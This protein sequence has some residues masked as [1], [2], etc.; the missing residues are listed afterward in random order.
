MLP[1]RAQRR[2]S[3]TL[4][5]LED[6]SL[7]ATLLF[8]IQP[9]TTASGTLL[10]AIEVT[11]P[12]GGTAPITVTLSNNPGAGQLGGTV[13]K[14]AVNGKA[15][16]ND[17]V[18]FGGTPAKGYTL[19]AYSAGDDPAFSQAFD[20]K[21]GAASLY[22]ATTIAP[23]PAGQ[24]LG[25]ITVQ[26][27]D[28]NGTLTRDD[29]TTQVRLVLDK[30]PGGARFVDASGNP[31]TTNPTAQ[32]SMGVATFPDVRLD[33]AGIGYTLKAITGANEL[34]KSG[35]S[36]RFQI[37]AGQATQL[38]FSNQPT[39][40]L[41]NQPINGGGRIA[42]FAAAG[43]TVQLL[44]RFNNPLTTGTPPI[45]VARKDG[46]TLGGLLTV[47]AVAG[48]A[49]FNSLTVP[50]AGTYTLTATA[51]GLPSADSTPFTVA[52]A[53]QPLKLQFTGTLPTQIQVGE[54]IPPVSVQVVDNNNNP[55]TG[56]DGIQIRLGPTGNVL[57][58]ATATLNARGQA[59]FS[60][61]YL[62]GR[63]IGTGAQVVLQANWVTLPFLPA[64]SASIPLAAGRAVRL[65]FA[66]KTIDNGTAG[67]Y[68]TANG[69]PIKVQVQ[70]AFGNVVTTATT[71]IFMGVNRAAPNSETTFLGTGPIAG[72]PS[73][74]GVYAIADAVAG[75]ATFD[76]VYIN[77]ASTMYQLAIGTL[78][79]ALQTSTSFPFNLV[80]GAANKVLFAVQPDTV[81]SRQRMTGIG[82]QITA[83][84]TDRVGNV[85][86]GN[87]TTQITMSLAQ[88]PGG[89]TLERRTQLTVKNGV[90]VFDLMYIE[91]NN[92]MSVPG[93]Q[94]QATAMGLPNP[95]AT[96]NT[97]TL[98]PP[99]GGVNVPIPDF[100][101]VTQPSNVG[102]NMPL[103]FSYRVSKQGQAANEYDRLANVLVQLLDGNNNPINQ[104]FAGINFTKQ[105]VNGLVTFA[106]DLRIIVAGQYK[107]RA[108][109]DFGA[110]EIISNTITIGAAGPA[111]VSQVSPTATLVNPNL[112]PLDLGS[113]TENFD[114]IREF[115][116]YRLQANGTPQP[117]SQLFQPP[118][119]NPVGDALPV[120][121]QPNV[122]AGFNQVPQSTK[123]WS[124]LM[125]QRT[126]AVGIDERDSAGNRLFPMFAD[127]YSMM[128]NSTG[129][130]A[131]LGLTN[132]TQ[133]YVIPAP[134]F[135]D[136]LNTQPDGRA[137]GNVEYF[138]NYSGVNIPDQR[139]YQDISVGLQGVQADA[140]VL[141]YSDYTVT[142]D[143]NG[144][145]QAT[146]GEGMPF[147]YFQA[148]NVTANTRMQVVTTNPN[149]TTTVTATDVNGNV[150]TAG[151]GPLRLRIQY[152]VMEKPFPL[153]NQ[154]IPVTVDTSYGVFL[155][156]G[157]AWTLTNG[158]L[159][160]ALTS[161]KNYFSVA[162]LPDNT[163][164]T[165]NFY[166]QRAYSHVTGSTTNFNYNETTG[167]LTTT[168]ALQT[169]VMES[170]GDLINNRPLQSLY[171]N[172]W[173]N[174][175]PNTPL[176]SYTYVSPRGTMKVFDGPI[177]VT[178]LQHRGTLPMVAPL[179]E[180]GTSHATLWNDYLLPYLVSISRASTLDGSLTLD[181]LIPN[182]QNN[183]LDFQTMLGA[184]QLIPILQEVS[185]SNDAALTPAD[186]QLAS[187]S[188]RRIF[189]IIKARLGA[190]LSALDDQDL[191]LFYYQPQ[192]L[193]EANAPAGIGW[194][195]FLSE[196]PGFSSSESLNDQHLIHGYF[197]K[198]AAIV[199]QYDSSWG[200]TRTTINNGQ[201]TLAGKLG[202]M[203]QRIIRNVSGYD[204]TDTEFP[205]LR[206]FDVFQ[207]HSW[208]DGAA[209]DPLGI[210]QESSSEAINYASALIQYGEA[211]GDRYVRDL[212][213][214][215]YNTEIE[216]FN[217]YYF[218]VNQTDAF[219]SQ[220][221]TNPN[222][223]PTGDNRPNIAI[224][225]SASAALRGFIG[226][227][228]SAL[229]GI[230]M[231]PLTGG[232]LYLGR[233]PAF[234]QRLYD[235]A[236]LAVRQVGAVPVTPSSYLS[237][238]DPYLALANAD[239]ARAKYLTDL[240]GIG[241]INPGVPIDTAAFNLHWIGVLQAYGQVDA[242]VT[243]DTV[244][245]GVFIK[246]T[247]NA[248]TRTYVAYNAESLPKTVTFRDATG[249]VVFTM[250]VPP[251]SMMASNVAGSQTTTQPDLD[252]SQRTPANRLFFSGTQDSNNNFTFLSGKT[253]AGEQV[254][255]IPAPGTNVSNEAPTS[256]MQKVTF[257]ITGVSGSLIS[258]TA[259]AF[260]S[261]WV[262]P[263]YATSAQTVPF[264]R[265]QITYD[266]DGTGTNLVKHLYDGFA[267]SNSPGYVNGVSVQGGGVIGNPSVVTYFTTLNNGTITVEIWARQG[268]TNTI[269]LRTDAAAEQGRVSYLDLPYNVTSVNG[270]PVTRLDLGGRAVV[271]TPVLV[272][273]GSVTTTAVSGAGR[274]YQ[275]K[276]S[277]DG[278]TATFAGNSASDTI[279]FQN[280]NGRLRHNRFTARDPGF[281]SDLDFDS[282]LPGEQTLAAVKSSNVVVN[283]GAG[284]DTVTLGTPQSPATALAA[285]FT[286]NNTDANGDRLVIND[287]AR[288]TLG[289]Y[290]TNGSSYTTTDDTLSVTLTGQAFTGGVMVTTGSAINAVQVLSTRRNEP[291]TLETRDGVDVV[292]IGKGTVRNVLGNVVV[293]N[294]NSFS[295][296]IVDNSQAVDF[297][298]NVTIS[299]TGITGLAPATISFNAR[300]LEDLQV[301]G[302]TSGSTYRLTGSLAGSFVFLDAGLGN[303]QVI[304][305]NNGV[306]SDATFP[307]KVILDGGLGSDT[308]TLD[309]ARGPA[310]QLV[311]TATGVDGLISDGLE[312]S[313]F[314][315]I[316][317][318]LGSGAD[319][320]RVATAQEGPAYRFDL[321]G[322]AD[323]ATVVPLA[324]PL[325]VNGQAGNDVLTVLD[326]AAE[327]SFPVTLN[328]A[329]G[330][331]AYALSANDST[332][333][334]VDTSGVDT[335]DFRVFTTG[336]TVRLT[337]TAG[338]TQALGLS[339]STLSLSGTWENV[340]G[341]EFD[342]FLVGNT[343]DN[344]IRGLGGNDALAGHSG[345]DLL[346]GGVGN[347]TLTA[348]AGNNILLGGAGDDTLN[349]STGRSVL[350]GGLGVDSLFAGFAGRSGSVLI[351]GTTTLDANEAALRM[352]LAEFASTRSLAVRIANLTNG[353]GSGQRLNGNSFFNSATLI[354]DALSNLLFGDSRFDWFLPF[355]ADRVIDRR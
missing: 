36:N 8:S 38:S 165:F 145:L 120:P 96:S 19:A 259:Q 197:I 18:I 43:V 323:T 195:A 102:V 139:L 59:T 216:S 194:Q 50:T 246:T 275:A 287:G 35:T 298:A 45:T 333:R 238:L 48:L 313:D 42:P 311:T 34:I 290:V 142:F 309:D 338:Q 209:N 346:D 354:D 307:G 317:V 285:R 4:E 123:W 269:R 254:V 186:K 265:A 124:S 21:A 119:A 336:V 75:V 9:T 154:L 125:F 117:N 223:P 193:N 15:T 204:R 20:V 294:S 211:T 200:D 286:I 167:Q 104:N 79:A 156:A 319:T 182:G 53:A 329:D 347:D 210:N 289:N 331:D 271:R 170:G 304:V 207:G 219:P 10:N 249:T 242:S 232:S 272:A 155:P 80:V 88:A 78:D 54:R 32:V 22:V 318:L 60:N 312:F 337:L 137:P 225:Y 302:G 2:R 208:A 12:A 115:D 131:G 185:V 144:Q 198:T 157:T 153:S 63:N 340:F 293:R 196:A 343:A 126:K 255:N 188:A 146:L 169:K 351:G 122:A 159:T 206:N 252:L 65:Q 177:F 349:G 236:T 97:F 6:R 132:L 330:N 234:V 71:K 267:L 127:P 184:A 113:Y 212:G 108:L 27:L 277:P 306:I 215:L 276:L 325:T 55:V 220:F 133:R 352:I 136:N 99:P 316:N 92:T 332:L 324:G 164:A 339:N 49:Q 173:R 101:V 175:A 174:L 52:S 143:W 40:T 150:V 350:I 201:Q 247:G 244:S 158:N 335:L 178:Q 310:R 303:D 110:Q 226:L 69:Q 67:E 233:D 70:D 279:V 171:N 135:I 13:T 301:F 130:F 140:K 230:Q 39:F 179:P 334:L 25:P 344:V 57:G 321:G 128:I 300:D 29:S 228:P 141:A 81:G 224:L 260:F 292:T 263:Q 328:G 68:L 231:L 138:Y 202:E 134:Q 111:S 105:P 58:N 322:G 87:S 315:Q 82:N 199:T 1:L 256:A 148:K 47:N 274:T 23:T 16:F 250:T 299:P 44:D 100:A 109:L 266:Q 118:S 83:I 72:D 342:D 218:N 46:G 129:T 187:T 116:A 262:D 258:D 282:F 33:K 41:T 66:N 273:P 94:L 235:Q 180:D 74:L 86:T 245:Y 107:I 181:Q 168:F 314:D 305:G 161:T 172:L 56:L 308:V 278:K 345:T 222:P 89:G 163:N 291:L 91:N 280:D 284:R 73:T 217:T 24:N 281:V 295:D 237:V 93:Y 240:P 214:Y 326:A 241:P 5:L 251:K 270:Q 7:L 229:A 221:T 162:V 320:I 62:L 203:V 189:E 213:I 30:N 243:A 37:V 192:K 106:N 149:R 147:A 176:T 61:T 166:R 28:A 248:A 183:Y 268:N 64:M 160:A 95:T 31:L 151:T 103:T 3:L 261:L 355:P 84:V 239:A 205:F 348:G 152:Q 297:T 227:I 90:A 191:K 26:L 76:Q 85:V 98:N 190:W 112:V 327:F 114:Y 288:T 264:V 253:G 353:S 51:L 341:T 121:V 257:K 283:L 296:L 77:R 11:D 17:L 14:P